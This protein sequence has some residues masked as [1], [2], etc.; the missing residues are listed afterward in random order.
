MRQYKIIARILL[1]LPIINFTFALPIEVQETRRDVVPDVTITKRVE[2][3]DNLNQ[4]GSHF[5]SLYGSP[6]VSRT[7]SLDHSV[8]SESPAV[9]KTPSLDHF[10]VDESPAVSKTPSLDHVVVDESPAVSKTPSLDHFVADESPAVLKTPSLGHFAASESP[11]A[12]KSTPLDPIA[13][14]PEVS[15][16]LDD[17][18]ASS[19]SGSVASGVSQSTTSSLMEKPGSGCFLCK[20][21]LGKLRFWRRISS[22]GSARDAVD[23]A[24]RELHGP[25]GTGAYVSASSLESQRF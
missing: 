17:H 4:W 11:E 15:T 25:V 18:G 12:L 8:A 20:A 6:D 19:S 16:P 21:V 14:L 10:V 13:V 24:K 7:P 5:D 2:E 1:I 22:P 3:T 9:S 23:A